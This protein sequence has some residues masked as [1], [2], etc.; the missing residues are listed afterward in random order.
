MSVETTRET[1]AGYVKALVE[2]GPYAQY[3]ADDVTFTVMGNE[4]VKGR[5]EV[6]EFIR[7]FHE[8]AFDARP[9][10][11]AIFSVDGHACLE[12]V[13]VGRH[14]GEFFGV[15]ASGH[16]VRVPYVV[17]YDLRGSKITALR[18]Y[19]PMNALMEQIKEPATAMP[20]QA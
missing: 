6:A 17:V 12:A 9:E 14:T 11:E 1:M 3:F 5:A 7:W 2:R 15:P 10:I 18:L 16:A 13:F 20:V 4:P 8:V 19:M